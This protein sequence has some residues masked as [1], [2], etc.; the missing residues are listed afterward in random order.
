MY[1][2]LKEGYTMKNLYL[3]FSF[4]FLL[5]IIS[6]FFPSPFLSYSLG[7]LS[8]IMLGISFFSA[9]RLFQILGLSFFVIGCGLFFSTDLSFIEVIP[10]LGDNLSLLTLLAVLPW[11]NSAV[12]AGRFDRLM[13]HLLKGNVRDLGMLYQRSTTAMMSLTAF[14]NVSSATI[15]Q[16]VLVDNLKPFKKKLADK[17][18][19]MT[20]LRGYSLALPW[21]PLEI[22]MAM[23]IFITGVNY[24]QI[25]PWMI[26]ITIL[27]FV[28]DSM[29]GRFYF[30]KYPYPKQAQVE[31]SSK[32]KQIAQLAIALCSF[33]LLVV[34]VGN[35]FDLDFI[36]I[37]TLLIFPFACLW[38]L[39][40]GRWRS[41]WKIGWTKW[42]NSMNNMHNFIVLF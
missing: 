41:F 4:V 34:V 37:V 29:W 19:M 3:F 13:Q 12:S 2:A 22:L 16:D 42:K 28:L 30:K 8:I 21:S 15:A 6:V 25:L 9:S 1:Y 5:H 26:F 32:R 24:S 17:F 39:V 36:L 18:I 27:M 31:N 40:I 23:A 38:A 20:T 35:L 14:L 10:F 11:M 33:L 7:I